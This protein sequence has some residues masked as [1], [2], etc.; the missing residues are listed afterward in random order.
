MVKLIKQDLLC[1]L[2]IGTEA[3]D[4]ESPTSMTWSQ[5]VDWQNQGMPWP[6]Q[7]SSTSSSEK[8]SPFSLFIDDLD[9]L[10]LLAT[11]SNEARVFLSK[12]LRHLHQE[13]TVSP[14]NILPIIYRK[15]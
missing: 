12:S 13:P 5:L 3:N 1:V 9:T 11:S 10:D 15:F 7:T 8:L 2:F 6:S 14:K 4:A